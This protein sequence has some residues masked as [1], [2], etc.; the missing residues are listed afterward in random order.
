MMSNKKPKF[1]EI[2]AENEQDFRDQFCKEVGHNDD[3]VND[4]VREMS[5]QLREYAY[6]NGLIPSEYLNSLT[7]EEFDKK[8]RDLLLIKPCNCGRTEHLN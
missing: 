6:S 3:C 1:V 7:V 2:T 8:L 5:I 4:T